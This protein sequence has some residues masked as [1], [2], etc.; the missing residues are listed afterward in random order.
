MKV[1]LD[2]SSDTIGFQS[3]KS[4]A[5]LSCHK[6]TVDS[7]SCFNAEISLYYLT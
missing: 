2:N 4:T 5:I 6:N 3:F 1:V 7:D